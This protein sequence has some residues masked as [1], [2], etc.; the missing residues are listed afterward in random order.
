MPEILDYH[1]VSDE[2]GELSLTNDAFALKNILNFG[3]SEGIYLDLF[4]EFKGKSYGFGTFKTL[5][6][7]REAMRRMGQLLG[8]FIYE[9]EDFVWKHDD[10]FSWDRFKAFF[11]G[12]DGNLNWGRCGYTT[13]E[14]ALASMAKDR[15][16]SAKMAECP[17]KFSHLL[18]RDNAKKTNEYFRFDGEKFVPDPEYTV[19]LEAS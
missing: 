11:A 15:R 1:L 9:F 16:N 8:D 14:E 19:D 10:D 5:K 18:V 6:D 3:A 4:L 17:E 13:K 2:A 7:D 12:D